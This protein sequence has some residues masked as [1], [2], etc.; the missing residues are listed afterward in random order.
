[1]RERIAS[2]NASWALQEEREQE[3]EGGRVGRET[4]WSIDITATVEISKLIMLKI[5]Q[6]QYTM[7]MYM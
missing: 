5:F 6:V 4:Q 3:R 2:E 1:M 7:Y